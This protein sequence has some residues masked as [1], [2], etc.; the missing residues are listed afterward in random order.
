LA[1]TPARFG[2]ALGMERKPNAKLTERD[3][4]RIRKL[5]RDRYAYGYIAEMMGCSVRMVAA[6]W[7]GG[8]PDVEWREPGTKHTKKG[9]VSHRKPAPIVPKTAV[10]S[11]K[12]TPK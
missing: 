7:N 9:Y 6:V 2:Y 10:K 12:A 1:T 8:R 5:R 3:Y 4:R 11:R